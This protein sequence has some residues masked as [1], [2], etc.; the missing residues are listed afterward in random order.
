MVEVVDVDARVPVLDRGAD[1]AG[2]GDAG[3]RQSGALRIGA[4]AVLEI[5]RDGKVGR[6]IERGGVLDDL[7]QGELPSRRPRVNAKPELVLASA[8]KPSAAKTRAEPG[9]SVW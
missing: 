7:I 5:D 6:P 4:V 2:L 1:G 3:E 8:L 9:V